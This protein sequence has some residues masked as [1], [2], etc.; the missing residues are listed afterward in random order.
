MKKIMAIILLLLVVLMGCQD[1]TKTQTEIL[2]DQ[3]KVDN[4]EMIISIIDSDITLEDKDEIAR[5]RAEYEKLTEAEKALVENYDILENAEAIIAG[6]EAENAKTNEV[7]EKA[8]KQIDEMI[9]DAVEDDLVFPSTLETEIGEV[10]LVW[11]IKDPNT[12]TKTG[13]VIQGR[14]TINVEI[15]TTIIINNERFA[16]SQMVAVKPIQFEK[17]PTN[18]LSFG[19]YYNGS[20]FTGFPEEALET[21]DVVNYAFA[22]VVNGEVNVYPL[23]SKD[24]VLKAR[25]SGVRIVMCIGGY[26]NEAIPFSKAASTQEGRE[27]L[28]AS[29]V[30]AVETYHF[31]GVD[32]D[33]EYPG[34]Y[35]S[36]E[37]SIDP[38]VDKVNYTLFM[39]ELR[40]Q[41]KAANSDYI[42][43]AAVP[44][45]DAKSRF[46]ISKL[47]GIL[48]YFH[49]MTYDMDSSGVSTHHTA[50]YS[51]SNSGWSAAGTV[52]EYVRLGASKSKLVLGAAF[53]GREFDLVTKGNV[54]R[55]Q[56]TA[57]RSI[58]YRY[59]KTEYIDLIGNGV[60][61]YWDDVAKAPYLYKEATNQVVVYDDEESIAYKAKYVID[62]GLAGMMFWEYSQDNGDLLKAIYENLV[63]ER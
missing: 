44:A 48:D 61:R 23:S 32:I 12:I 4:V 57:K 41:L 36:P 5:I 51:S 15:M 52:D 3:D 47:N 29:I 8:K 10:K 40:K 11:G 25:K 20:N 14:R 63:K 49:L 27:K 58:N 33:W 42:L 1:T 54:I 2:P 43:S 30:E 45:G 59:I 6:I 17:L 50:L 56:A 53:Y 38:A 46:E 34:Y 26:A 19:Y 31:D 60:T 16:T 62:E 37:Y 35:D 28:A 9:P 7:I 18:R 55:A 24:A 21:L 39:T 13:Q 22:T